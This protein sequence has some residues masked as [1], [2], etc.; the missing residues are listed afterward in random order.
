MAYIVDALAAAIRVTGERVVAARIG[1]QQAV[2]AQ[3]G[4]DSAVGANVEVAAQC[5]QPRLV[6]SVGVKPTGVEV[7][8][9]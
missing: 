1:I 7:R 5:V 2:L 6:C 3:R 9:P 8:A 4:G